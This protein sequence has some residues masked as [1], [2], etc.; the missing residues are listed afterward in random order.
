ML[1]T[2]QNQVDK[3]KIQ[4]FLLSFSLMA[5]KLEIFHFLPAEAS[6][7]QVHQEN[8][9]TCTT[10]H[11]ITQS[12]SKTHSD[13]NQKLEYSD[14]HLGVHT[15]IGVEAEIDALLIFYLANLVNSIFV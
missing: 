8:D 15:Q 5:T 12:P 7:H 10:F 14:P 13:V 9:Y 2:H 3:T 6:Q 4:N 1:T 11:Q